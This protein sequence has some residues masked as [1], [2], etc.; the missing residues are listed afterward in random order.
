[1]VQEPW[2]RTNDTDL[3]KKKINNQKIPKNIV[4]C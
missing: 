4:Y 3:K 2:A 1:M